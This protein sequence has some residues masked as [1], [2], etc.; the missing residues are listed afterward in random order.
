MARMECHQTLTN[1]RLSSNG[2]S[3]NPMQKSKTFSKQLH[4]RMS[5][6]FL[7]GKHGDISYP[8]L[9]TPH[10]D[11][12]KKNL[13][14]YWGQ[15]QEEAFQQIKDRLCSND[16]LVPYNISLEA[17]LY[18]NSSPVGTRATVAH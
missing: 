9:T 15:E 5:P 7:A 14:F 16:V 6:K 10:R 3:P 18:V 17:R 4:Y 8:E 11:L 1:A 2:H 12:M 13:R